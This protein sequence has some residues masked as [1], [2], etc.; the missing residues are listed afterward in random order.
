LSVVIAAA[1]T[2]GEATSKEGKKQNRAF[3]HEHGYSP[4]ADYS[5]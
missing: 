4:F 5:Q 2:S 3:V 1:A